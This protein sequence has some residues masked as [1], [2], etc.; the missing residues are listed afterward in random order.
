MANENKGEYREFRD[1]LRRGIGTRT[2]KAFAEEVGISKEHLNRMLNNR[3]ISRPT[4]S[5]LRK[6]ASHMETITERMLLEACGYEVED[7]GERI[8][9]CEA[10]LAEGLEN[11]VNADY[12]Q[13]WKSVMDALQ[14]VDLLYLEENG[15]FEFDE[16]AACTE[17]GHRLA[18]KKTGFS[19]YWGNDEKDCRTKG[20][21]FFSRTENGNLIFL[22]QEVIGTSIQKKRSSAEERL[23]QVI[24]GEDDDRMVIQTV[25]GYGFRY[26]STPQGF[27][28]FLVEYRGAFCTNRERSK[29]LLQIIDE[30][31]DPD[32]VFKDFQTDKYGCGT[33]GAVAEI[34]SREF[35]VY[36]YYYTR[37]ETLSEEDSVSSILVNDKDYFDSGIEKHQFLLKLQRA[38]LALQIP[39]F[40]HMCHSYLMPAQEKLYD[41]KTFGYEFKE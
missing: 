2:Q 30:G 24:F 8:K 14:T 29:M 10:S 18:E 35:G 9:R 36:F 4:V 12:Q 20:T 25:F 22:D 27:A 38:V 3:E 40:G 1:L 41:A 17:G 32:E 11:L 34:L 19:Y 15:K 13:P 7:I 16:E 21:I 33:G 5:I 6:M 26:P 23:L 31:K 28:D 39:E 37:E